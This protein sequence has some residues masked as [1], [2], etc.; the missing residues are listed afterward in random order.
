MAPV[1]AA[2]GPENEDTF[3]I[4]PSEPAP[5]YPGSDAPLAPETPAVP[6]ALPPAAP[7]QAAS[8]AAGTD[9]MV[10]AERYKNLQA[11][12]TKVAQEN[13]AFRKGA[14][15]AQQAPGQAQA[16][17]QDQPL[18]I[19]GEAY[20]ANKYETLIE[21]EGFAAATEYRDAYQRELMR[22]DMQS[23]FQQQ[24]QAQ[25]QEQQLQQEIE[26]AGALF[27]KYGVDQNAY[28]QMEQLRQAE[29]QRGF[30]HSPE[31]MIA[32]VQAGGSWENV[33]AY[34]NYGMQAYQQ[35]QQQSAAAPAPQAAHPGMPG[36]VGQ[37][38]A[39]QA[40]SAGAY[41]TPQSIGL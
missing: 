33:L 34:M 17:P 29:A 8:A 40:R 16:A 5:I 27:E 20:S 41:I 19:N 30:Q 2:F 11:W 36:G 14:Q 18:M 24:A 28:E 37:Q 31:A 7:A 12:A 32:M 13:A 1:D 22:R 38:V 6:A 39:P 10:A 23:V 3:E 35:A 15:L 9:Q 25:T 21:D 4:D 26:K